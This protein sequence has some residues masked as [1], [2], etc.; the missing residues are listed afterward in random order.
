MSVRA[1]RASIEAKSVPAVHAE[2]LGELKRS[3]LAA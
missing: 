1:V 3:T 2:I